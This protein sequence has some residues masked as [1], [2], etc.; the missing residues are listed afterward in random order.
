M[1]VSPIESRRGS[2]D[3]RI[4]DALVDSASPSL[5]ESD[6]TA[7]SDSSKTAERTAATTADTSEP[8]LPGT[9][10][11][12][13]ESRCEVTVVGTR[14]AVDRVKVGIDGAD[15][16]TD[17]IGIDED[18]AEVDIDGKEAATEVASD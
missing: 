2:A 15:V 8:I 10:A 9:R 12:T 7:D 3:R 11:D 6:F 14:I 4:E 17:E 1:P 13:S 5:V 18:G 16:A